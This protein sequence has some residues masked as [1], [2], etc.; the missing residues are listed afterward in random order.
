MI[1]LLCSFGHFISIPSGAVW[2]VLLGLGIK[3]S[4]VGKVIDRLECESWLISRKKQGQGSVVEEFYQDLSRCSVGS[5]WCEGARVR[6]ASQR[7][8]R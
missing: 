3:L 5:E 7:G 2:V 4:T 6:Q 8:E 1:H